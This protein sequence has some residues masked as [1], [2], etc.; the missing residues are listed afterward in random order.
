MT[1]TKDNVPIPQD[2]EVIK[3]IVCFERACDKRQSYAYLK[4][5]RRDGREGTVYY[6]YINPHDHAQSDWQNDLPHDLHQVGLSL[7]QVKSLAAI[8]P[9][10]ISTK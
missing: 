10:E 1:N 5:K 3:H 9:Y 2:V 4:L 6:E 8:H 7:K